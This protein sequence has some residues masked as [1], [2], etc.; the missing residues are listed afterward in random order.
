MKSNND[1]IVY[2]PFPGEEIE[3]TA[4]VIADLAAA[5]NK[6]VM[7][8]FNNIKLVATPGED[9]HTIIERYHFEAGRIEDQE[10]YLSR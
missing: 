7:A 10:K 4:R 1:V 8:L 5:N 9:P 2:N 6:T 3:R